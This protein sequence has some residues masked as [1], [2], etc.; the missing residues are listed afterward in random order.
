MHEH[1][2]TKNAL[3]KGQ[4]LMV[5]TSCHSVGDRKDT[6]VWL[7]EVAV[8]YYIFRDNGYDVTIC[9][10]NGGEVPVDQAGLSDAEKKSHPELAHFLV[11]D[12]A[13]LQLRNSVPLA[14]VKEPPAYACV[15]LAGGHG[16][17]GDMPN[18]PEL[19]RVVGEMARLGH[20]VAAVC[21]G[22][23]GLLGVKDA[24]GKPLVAG[25]TVACFTPAEEEKTGAAASMPFQLE[26]KLKELGANVRCEGVDE[27]NAV[28]D[29]FLVTGQNH[30]SSARVASLVLEALSVHPAA[31][32]AAIVGHAAGAV[33]EA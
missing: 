29:T 15:F 1:E 14:S 24:E 30:N 3:A 8:P 11:D 27:E 25:K 26:A 32:G 17:M 4:V 2:L 19:A 9:S 13:M 28:R 12:A 23:A 20:L 5:C 6:G 7:S 18:N 10:I 22:P 16:A 31:P 33:A 21:H